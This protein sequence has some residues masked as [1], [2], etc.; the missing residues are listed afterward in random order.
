[1]G[2]IGIAI[3]FAAEDIEATN[4]IPVRKYMQPCS[5]NPPYI[6]VKDRRPVRPLYRERFASCSAARHALVPPFCGT[7]SGARATAGHRTPGEAPLDRGRLAGEARVR[8]K[9]GKLLSDDRSDSRH[10]YLNCHHPRH[11]MTVILMGATDLPR[12]HPRGHERD[13]RA[14]NSADPAQDWCGRLSVNQTD[15]RDSGERGSA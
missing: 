3:A 10:Q 1:M 7:G 6:T 2:I 4:A 13:Q 14:D 9:F 5:G 12:R 15:Q 11:G 8:Q